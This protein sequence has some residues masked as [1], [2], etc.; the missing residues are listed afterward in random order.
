[1]VQQ[2]KALKEV[3]CV[4]VCDVRGGGGSKRGVASSAE[5]LAVLQHLSSSLRTDKRVYCS[6]RTQPCGKLCQRI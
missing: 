3:R 1:M 2:V 6:H 4:C 5:T